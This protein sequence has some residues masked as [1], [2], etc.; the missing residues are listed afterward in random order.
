V[1]GGGGVGGWVGGWVV[2][3]CVWVFIYLSMCVRE[4]ERECVCVYIYIYI[5]YILCIYIGQ[6]QGRYV[7]YVYTYIHTYIHTY[8]YIYIYIYRP[9][10]GAQEPGT[11]VPGMARQ[12]RA[13]RCV[14]VKAQVLKVMPQF[15][16]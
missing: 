4:R 5:M 3:G 2:C 10:A 8:I 6:L 1:W 11:P 16:V 7:I 14:R 12:Q 15:R 9:D 13:A